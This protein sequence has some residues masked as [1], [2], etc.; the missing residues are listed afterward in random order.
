M[1]NNHNIIKKFKKK[2]MK[3]YTQMLKINTNHSTY[4]NLNNFIDKI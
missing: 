3:N 1:L 4:S 2:V